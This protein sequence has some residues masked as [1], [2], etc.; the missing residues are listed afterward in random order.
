M[1]ILSHISKVEST[2]VNSDNDE[3][4]GS[5]VSSLADQVGQGRVAFNGNKIQKEQ[6]WQ[7]GKTMT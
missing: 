7:K 1:K 2:K 4:W 5:D 3:G 6:I